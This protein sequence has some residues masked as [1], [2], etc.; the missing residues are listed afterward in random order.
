MF[1][2]NINPGFAVIW[3]FSQVEK[4]YRQVA[5]NFNA[6]K[7]QKIQRALLKEY[8]GFLDAA[9]QQIKGRTARSKFERVTELF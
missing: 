7:D 4:I 3:T 6:S 2:L 1:T 9:L 5:K 8:N